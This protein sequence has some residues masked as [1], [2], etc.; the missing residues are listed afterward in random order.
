MIAEISQTYAEVYSAGCFLLGPRFLDERRLRRP[1]RKGRYS[2]PWRGGYSALNFFRS[3][4]SQLPP[5]Y[6]PEV[7]EIAYASPGY[8]EIV[9][10]CAAISLVVR[11]V[12]GNANRILDTAKKIEDQLKERDLNKLERRRRRAEVEFIE[13]AY[14]ELGHSFEL[15][16]DAMRKLREETRDDSWARLKILLAIARRIERLARYGRS[17]TAV[18]EEAR[19]ATAVLESTRSTEQRRKLK[20]HLHA[21]LPPVDEGDSVPPSSERG[22]QGPRNR[23]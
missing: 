6:R 3:I 22:G 1:L 4:Y 15:P 12:T 8:I 21:G 16:G 18:L 19:A 10:Y 7:L 5:R 17:G 23:K 2:Y 11:T 20:N 14:R 13:Q 9:G